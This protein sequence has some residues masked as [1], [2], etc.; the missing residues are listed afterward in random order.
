MRF[1]MFCVYNILCFFSFFCLQ[2]PTSSFSFSLL[3]FNLLNYKCST[4]VR[5]TITASMRAKWDHAV[6]IYHRCVCGLQLPRWWWG[7]LRH[8]YVR[9]KQCGMPT[10]F[11]SMMQRGFKMLINNS[12]GSTM[13]CNRCCR[14]MENTK[15]TEAG[16]WRLESSRLECLGVCV[17]VCVCVFVFG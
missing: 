11:L 12:I 16:T 15:Q 13:G 14:H 2:L 10:K 6:C 3:L 7:F 5:S 17:C 4:P 1:S 9:T 8:G